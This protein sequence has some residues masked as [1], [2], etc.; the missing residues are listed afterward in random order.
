MNPYNLHAKIKQE[1][2][3]KV[4]LKSN[5]SNREKS[6]KAGTSNP[7]KLDCP[8]LWL[9]LVEQPNTHQGQQQQK[10]QPLSAS[11]A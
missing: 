4:A 11:P 2:S 9:C 1:L 7:V 8:S 6:F 5:Q 10:A 3:I